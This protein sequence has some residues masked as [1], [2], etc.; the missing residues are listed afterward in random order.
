MLGNR[1][2]FYIMLCPCGCFVTLC[3]TRVAIFKTKAHISL[4]IFKPQQTIL[5]D[6][7]KNN[8]VE[9]N[10]NSD[11]I[12]DND[13]MMDLEGMAPNIKIE[14]AKEF[15]EREDFNKND[16]RNLTFE[17]NEEEDSQREMDGTFSNSI[18]GYGDPIDNP[19]GDQYD[20]QSSSESK[21]AVLNPTY[22]KE[23]KEVEK[24]KN[25][26][27]SLR[28]KY[29]K[30]SAL[31]YKSSLGKTETKVNKV[32]TKDAA[33]GKVEFNRTFTL[34][35][36]EQLKANTTEQL[37]A[38][39]KAENISDDTNNALNASLETK[40][41]TFEN[42]S[43]FLLEKKSDEKNQTKSAVA[44]LIEPE[45]DQND[46]SA[47]V[48]MHTKNHKILFENGNETLQVAISEDPDIHRQKSDKSSLLYEVF[49]NGKK[50]FSLV[51]GN[52][53]N[54]S[55]QVNEIKKKP[56]LKYVLKQLN[57]SE[58]EN[59]YLRSSVLKKEKK[60]YSEIRFPIQNQNSFRRKKKGD[61]KTITTKKQNNQKQK[62]NKT[63]C[64]YDI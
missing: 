38:I 32:A 16:Q 44:R 21:Q 25:F 50:S 8:S 14:V 37:K 60:L 59:L 20:T 23:K 41:N 33:D 22:E 48:I 31:Y 24:V 1:F 61:N 26:K 17:Y 49:N 3:C 27:G 4:E 40:H 47:S 5:I 34:N 30:N 18:I 45:M 7:L 2:L 54:K 58:V 39:S 42:V 10:S 62:F 53:N 12:V 15:E 28:E 55:I 6:D 9:S 57:E 64:N 56:G 19:L 63:L 29:N 36:T 13:R 35:T 51:E 11:V 43:Q 46:K 52:K